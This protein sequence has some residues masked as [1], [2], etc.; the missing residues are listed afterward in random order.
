MQ[1]LLYNIQLEDH[2]ICGDSYTRITES[3]F[4]GYQPSQLYLLFF[5]LNSIIMPDSEL[6]VPH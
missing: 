2:K 3:D 6:T 1:L 4:T 5:H